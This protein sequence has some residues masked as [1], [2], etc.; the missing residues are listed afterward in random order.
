[1]IAVFTFQLNDLI[2][3]LDMPGGREWHGPCNAQIGLLNTLQTELNVTNIA[4]CHLIT[5]HIV[6]NFDK[7]PAALELQQELLAAQGNGT[8][9]AMIIRYWS[10]DPSMLRS[11]EFL[12]VNIGLRP[13]KYEQFCT[14]VKRH[15]DGQDLI[16]RIICDLVGFAS[17]SQSAA[18]ITTM[19]EFLKGRPYFTL[20]DYSF[21]F[22]AKPR[23]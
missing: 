16:G 14:F 7:Q 4:D 11:K 9:D 22:S 17:P 19:D 23:A 20:G 13:Q 10:K 18:Q 2:T 5:S 12:A 15:F 1:M 8:S 21:V 3:G 6:E